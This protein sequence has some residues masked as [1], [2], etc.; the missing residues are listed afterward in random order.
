[1]TAFSR[2]S[3]VLAKSEAPSAER[4]VVLRRAAYAVESDPLKNEAE[5]DA[6][7]NDAEPDY[8]AWLAAVAAIKERYPLPD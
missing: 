3:S 4:I 7:I 2:L 6:M 8:A 5:F 1:V